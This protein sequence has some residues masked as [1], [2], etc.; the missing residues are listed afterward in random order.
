MTADKTLKPSFEDAMDRWDRGNNAGDGYAPDE[1]T[2][3][4]T[5]RQAAEAAGM[6][7]IEDYDEAHLDAVL[8][9]D[10][11]KWVVVANCNGPWAVNVAAQEVR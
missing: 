10:A 9:W 3:E 5:P 2:A 7:D 4:M 11:H 8:A 6:T 1:S